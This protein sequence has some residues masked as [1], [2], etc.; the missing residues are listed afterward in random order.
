MPDY[1][2]KATD[3]SGTIIKGIHS[4]G[5][6]D[7]LTLYLERTGFHLLYHKETRLKRVYSFKELLT[8]GTVSRRDLIEFS[9]SF[10]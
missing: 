9:N 10:N 7:E 6:V 1:S 4:A 3:A 8:L 5:S 2:Y